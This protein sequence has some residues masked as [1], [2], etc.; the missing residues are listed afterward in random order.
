MACL[1][2]KEGSKCNMNS[3]IPIA[4]KV[5][6]FIA[7]VL[8]PVS[9]ILMGSQ[10]FPAPESIS[11]VLFAAFFTNRMSTNGVSTVMNYQPDMVRRRTHLTTCKVSNSLPPP[12]ISMHLAV[13]LAECFCVS[14]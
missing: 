5:C 12:S 3:Q 2:S 10:L 9:L 11:L 14:K 13:T 7:I 4:N 1:I 6:K 8:L